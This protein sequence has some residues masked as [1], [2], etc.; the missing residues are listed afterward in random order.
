MSWL[1]TLFEPRVHARMYV[2][3]LPTLLSRWHFRCAWNQPCI[4]IATLIQ[5]P[6]K[7]YLFTFYTDLCICACVN[8]MYNVYIHVHLHT[9]AYM[10]IHVI[11]FS[12]NTE[13]NTCHMHASTIHPLPH[14]TAQY[15]HVNTCTYVYMHVHTC[16]MNWIISHWS[17][18]SAWPGR[19][20][21]TDPLHCT[22]C[23]PHFTST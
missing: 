23:S 5:H 8:I 15:I 20:V 3:D 13:W 1:Y 21:Y 11:F 12:K 19:V 17:H 22:T 16:G 14:S 10:Y 9:Y 2:N 18:C 6:H 7:N 4:I